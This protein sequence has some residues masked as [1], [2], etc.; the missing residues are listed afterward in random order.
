M[1]V[2]TMNN[3]GMVQGPPQ[4][5]PYLERSRTIQS[6]RASSPHPGGSRVQQHDDPTVTEDSRD[7]LET[8]IIP[9]PGFTQHHGSGRRAS[10]RPRSHSSRRSGGSTRRTSR[11]QGHYDEYATDDTE[12]PYLQRIDTHQSRSTHHRG[13]TR[14]RSHS[15]H[16][17]AST[18]RSH[19]APRRR[20]RSIR[21]ERQSTIIIDMPNGER[22]EAFADIRY[23][24]GTFTYYV[25]PSGIKTTFKVGEKGGPITPL[26]VKDDEG[27][28]IHEVRDPSSHD[29]PGYVSLKPHKDSVHAHSTGTDRSGEVLILWSSTKRG[30]NF[31]CKPLRSVPP[32]FPE[33][34]P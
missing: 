9:P 11:E 1:E 22:F 13:R 25:V 26:V 4:S 15:R 31:P 33:P 24:T 19:R 23:A 8:P 2:L 28:V 27:H 14:T 21:P 30:D 12:H 20:H 7:D 5:T 29:Y 32:Y 18:S 6:H 3:L 16:S 17:Q 34:R 10:S